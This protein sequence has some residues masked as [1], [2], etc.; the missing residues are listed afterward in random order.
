MTVRRP[1]IPAMLVA[2]VLAV[3]CGEAEI[4]LAV[5]NFA[6]RAND[7]QHIYDEL[8]PAE[9]NCIFSGEAKLD[10]DLIVTGTGPLADAERT[11]AV[12]NSLDCVDDPASWEGW[13]AL[14]SEAFAAGVGMGVELDA[15]E[16]RCLVAY[17]LDN[18]SD[19]ARMF[20]VGD[21]QADFLIAADAIDACFDDENLSLLYGETVAYDDYGDD[22]SLD[23]LHD[24]CRAGDAAS[25]DLL[26]LLSGADTGYESIAA[27][28]G[29][30]VAAGGALCTAIE[31]D[32]SG[33]AVP[34]DPAYADLRDECASG[35]GVACDL[36]FRL[37]E[38]GS[39]E[40][41][42]GLT[43]GGAFP[44]GALPDCRTVLGDP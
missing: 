6:D 42:F 17:L 8:T 5:D 9:R 15:E 7:T 41:E 14:Q 19:P 27:S 22:A 23:L 31:V 24:G 13:V 26:F 37:A 28:C 33:Y 38:I 12:Q 43:C 18:T 29:E 10:A 39:P 21:S 32:R 44:T 30:T 2:A 3:A 40:E 1:P 20:A 11:R 34:G 35:D 36:Y 4:P 16:G 25:C